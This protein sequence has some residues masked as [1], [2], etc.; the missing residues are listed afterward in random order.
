MSCD[1]AAIANKGPKPR[2]HWFVTSTPHDRF[3]LI[4]WVLL[5]GNRVKVAGAILIFVYLSLLTVGQVWSNSIQVILT[6]T[7]TIQS[8][9]ET[10]L[11]GVILLVSIVVSINSIVIAQDI[12]SVQS[13][14]DQTRGTRNF[15][16]DIGAMTKTGQ[17]PSD[18]RAFLQLMATEIAE[19]AQILAEDV[20]GIEGEFGEDVK[21]YTES[22]VGSIE[23]LAEI[24]R[25]DHG[26]FNALWTALEVDYGVFLERSRTLRG[27]HRRVV[28]ES[29]D[30]Q[31]DRLVESIQLFA[32]GRE[33]FKTLY[34]YK[35]ISV[36]SRTLLIVSLPTIL[37]ITMAIFTSTAGL[38]P[39]VWLVW[40]L[41]GIPPIQIFVVTAFT[42]ALVPYVVLTSYMLRLTTV[43]IRTA[44]AGPFSLND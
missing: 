12:E 30:E 18:P 15:R 9:L 7:S 19:R 39:K 29:Y 11:S 16:N 42:I 13:E 23:H 44:S 31:L 24:D 21:T 34:Y 27:E 6:E 41:F 33:H 40:E 25:V 43:G 38:F 20:E 26:E 8:I 10:F 32:I 1:I 17:S 22:V 28:T 35:E 3:N 36:L 4:R 5:E 2:R 14:T 37:I